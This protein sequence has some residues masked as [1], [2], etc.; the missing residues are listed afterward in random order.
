MEAGPWERVRWW[1]ETEAFVSMVGRESRG[2]RRD[3]GVVELT[4]LRE[5]G[6]WG[7]ELSFDREAEYD[8]VDGS[9]LNRG[10]D[11]PTEGEERERRSASPPP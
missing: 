11:S 8:L 6:R 7:G 9:E 1:W 4:R 5:T 2:W 10:S 3:A